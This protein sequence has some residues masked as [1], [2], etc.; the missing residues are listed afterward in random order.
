MFQ[1]QPVTARSL[2]TMIRLS[3]AHA[4]CRLS[5]T[6]DI[7]DAQA[8]VEL[9]QF[10]YFKKV[11]SPWTLISE[12]WK[13]PGFWVLSGKNLVRENVQKLFV[14]RCVFASVWVSRSIQRMALIFKLLSLW[15]SSVV[16]SLLT[17]T[18]VLAWYE[19]H[20][21]RAGVPGIFRE[22]YSVWIVICCLTSIS[23]KMFVIYLQNVFCSMLQFY[24]PSGKAM[25]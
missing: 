23:D 4:K 25:K 17:I 1:T 6:I 9:V 20:L 3:T 14:V 18:L 19:Y 12:T 7:E 24:E 15:S 22:F 13:C 16:F 21:T 8:A 10:A 2:E 5:K 11:C